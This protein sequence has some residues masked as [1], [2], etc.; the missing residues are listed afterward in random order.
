MLKFPETKKYDAIIIA[1]SHDVFKTMGAKKI[2]SF[3]KKIH[4][5]YDL[6]FIL[7]FD[8]VDLRL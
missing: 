7:S 5:I 1:V 6:K 8:D 4:V 3:G 2:H